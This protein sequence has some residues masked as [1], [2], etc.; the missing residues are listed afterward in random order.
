[1][2]AGLPPDII[3]NNPKMGALVKVTAERAVDVVR[4]KQ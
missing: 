4:A 1:M 2:N 3:P